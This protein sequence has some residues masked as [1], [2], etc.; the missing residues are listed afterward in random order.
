M[1]DAPGTSEDAALGAPPPEPESDRIGEAQVEAYRELLLRVTSDVSD[2]RVAAI[3]ELGR[4]RPR[5]RRVAELMRQLAWQDELPAEREAARAALGD[6]GVELGEPPATEASW[7]AEF[8]KKTLLKSVRRVLETMQTP[9]PDRDILEEYDRRF[10][11]QREM[12]EIGEEEA[13]R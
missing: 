10:D 12:S 4:A 7:L 1:S 11:R 9:N 13:P 2:E 3:R 6:M 5:V 8:S